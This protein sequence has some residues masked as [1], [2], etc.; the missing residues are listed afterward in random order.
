MRQMAFAYLRTNGWEDRRK[1]YLKIEKTP[2]FFRGR[3]IDI[4]Q[5]QAHRQLLVS[6]TEKHE[7]TWEA[8]E[9]NWLGEGYLSL[10]PSAFV[11]RTQLS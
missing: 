4:E 3:F 2:S 5:P 8:K 11:M 7:T 9:G 6:S 10:S 1:D